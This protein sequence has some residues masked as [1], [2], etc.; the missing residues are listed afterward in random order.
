MIKVGTLRK[1]G[2][3]LP[4]PLE[5]GLRRTAWA[6]IPVRHQSRHRVIL[7]CC[8]W[9]T[10]S[11]WVRTILADPRV[12]ARSGLR[13]QPMSVA[14]WAALSTTDQV[15]VPPGRIYSPVYA[16]YSSIRLQLEAAH[17]SAFFVCRDPRDLLVS[18]YFSRLSAHPPTDGIAERRRTLSGL[19]EEEGLL[20]VLKDFDTIIGIGDDWI[21]QASCDPRVLM[22]RYEDLTGDD[23]VEYWS[24]LFQHLDIDMPPQRVSKL[25]AT[26]SF[27]N[28][29]GGRSPGVED[30]GHK[31]RKG[32]PGDWKLHW[33]DSVEEEMHR[34][35]GDVA[36]RWGYTE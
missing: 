27:A 35:F 33:H 12:Y 11:Q 1:L 16:P 20:E 31:Y 30:A 17:A 25:L 29:T 3:Q 24:S 15:G 32:V 36:S 2:R 23:S 21:G 10:A 13:C 28:I 34:R 9:K 26:Y 7:H 8:T 18:R 22:T 4:R 14:R 19:S 5:R 6:V